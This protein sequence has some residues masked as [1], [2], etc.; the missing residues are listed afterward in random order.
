[1]RRERPRLS[2][3]ELALADTLWPDRRDDQAVAVRR[4]VQ[5]GFRSNPKQ[6]QDRLVDDDARAVPDGLETLDHGEVI[7]L[8]TTSGKA[9]SYYV[10]LANHDRDVILQRAVSQPGT[11]HER[12]YRRLQR[13]H[14][15]SRSRVGH[16]PGSSAHER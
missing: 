3:C 15:S 6:L 1:M 16:E 4:D 8:F 2:S 12:V 9:G 7:T 10:H 11:I 13:A 14:T 5:L